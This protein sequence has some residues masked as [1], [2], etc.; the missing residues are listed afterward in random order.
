MGALALFGAALLW[1]HCTEFL[2]AIAFMREDLSHRC[3]CIVFFWGGGDAGALHANKKR[4]P[5]ADPPSLTRRLVE[6]WA[7][8]PHGVHPNNPLIPF[9]Q[10]ALLISLPYTCAMTAAVL[11]YIIE[12][13]LGLPKPRSLLITGAVIAACGDALRKAAMITAR[14]AFRHDLARTFRAG[15]TLVT[16]GPYALA[17]HPGYLGFAAFAVGTQVALANPV[18]AAAFVIATRR[19]FAARVAIEERLLVR[20]FGEDYIE[21]AARTPTWMPGVG[22]VPVREDRRKGGGRH[23]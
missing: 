6:L 8:H 13:R 22:V 3:A 15:H 19:F 9:H 5:L 10:P 17:R 2:L 21:Y 16:H 1:F 11:E 14:G 20:F 4:D 7:G 18:C 23:E 12:L